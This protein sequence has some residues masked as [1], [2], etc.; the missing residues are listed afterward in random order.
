[1][2]APTKLLTLVAGGIMSAGTIYGLITFTHDKLQ[3]IDV[4]GQEL[5]TLREEIKDARGNVLLLGIKEDIRWTQH[6]MFRIQEVYGDELTDAPALVR[7][8]YKQ[9]K[10]DLENLQQEQRATQRAYKAL[11]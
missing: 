2:E 1:M 4:Q 11:R 8:E 3:A 10:I 7:E 6:R 5:A 9:S